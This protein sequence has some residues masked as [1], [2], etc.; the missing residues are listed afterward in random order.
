MS[1]VEFVTSPLLSDIPGVRHGFFTRK[2]GVSTRD[3]VLAGL[4]CGY[5]ADDDEQ[6]VTENRRLALNALSLDVSRLVTLYQIHSAGV[7]TAVAPWARERAPRSDGMVTERRNLA[8]GILTADCAPVLFCDPEGRSGQPVI[9]ACH[10]GWKGAIGGVLRTTLMA[11]RDLGADIGRVRAVIGPTISARSYEVGP[12]F[13]E[14]F[15]A[16]DPANSDFFGPSQRPGHF[17][18][19]LPGFIARD[20]EGLGV[21]KVENTGLDTLGDEERFFSYRRSCLQGQTD[22][23]RLLSVIALEP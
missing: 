20:L 1:S 15:L 22:Y 3:G 16:A 18:F 11:M 2:G 8:L 19:D 14:P 12:E 9:G 23:G 10:A 21:A 7:V 13:P 6:A 5:G 17:M 4:N